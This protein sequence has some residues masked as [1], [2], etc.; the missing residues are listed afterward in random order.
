[1]TPF[2]GERPEF[3]KAGDLVNPNALRSRVKTLDLFAGIGEDLVQVERAIEAALDTNDPLVG[4][5]S[6]HL[7]KAGGKRIR[8]ALVLL[9]SRFPGYKLETALPAAVAVELIH[10]ATL[11]HDDVV[12]KA[13]TRRGMPTVNARW[14]NQVS[15]LT[16]D[17]LFA[18]AFS[19]LA[20]TGNNRLVQI[21]ADVVHLMSRGELHQ[22]ASYFQVDQSEAD[23]LERI[24][25][26]TADFIAESCRLGALAGGGT[27]AEVEACY[28]YGL[29]VGLS[30][31][32]VDDLLDFMGSAGQVGKPVGGDLRTGILTM[33][34]LHAL[35]HSPHR[36][37]LAT[38]IA[39]QEI[40]EAD[41]ETVKVWLEASGSFAYSRERADYYLQ[42]ALTQLNLL[43]RL[44]TRDSLATVA[45]FVINRQF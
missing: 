32:I 9:A 10:M 5:V 18:K 40:S 2:L 33:P 21:M 36:E 44:S 28:Q 30:F 27:E 15:V 17:Y 14:S 24:R 12:D 16:G 4:E 20:Q 38:L 6:T 3:V 25:A 43:E 11:V 26:K 31:Q 29:N 22:S 35:Q 45:E 37:E 23:Y 41:I 42:Q 8:P 39:S 13:S 1:M 34:V 19:L 7:L